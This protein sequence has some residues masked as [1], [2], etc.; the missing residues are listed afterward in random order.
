MIPLYHHVRLYPQIVNE[1][2]P[3]LFKLLLR[4]FDHSNKYL[5]SVHSL[6][7]ENEASIYYVINKCLWGWSPD[8]EILTPNPVFL[9][10]LF[11]HHDL[12]QCWS[13]PVIFLTTWGLFLESFWTQ[14]PTNHFKLEVIAKGIETCS[15]PLTSFLIFIRKWRSR[16]RK[17]AS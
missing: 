17:Y 2:K 11:T 5:H 4:I 7:K 16:W 9:M 15:F 1:N 8:S 14:W 13:S 3:F 6:G 10:T 12:I